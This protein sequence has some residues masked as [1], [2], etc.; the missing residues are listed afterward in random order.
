MSNSEKLGLYLMPY[1][2]GSFNDAKHLK[3]CIFNHLP[4]LNSFEFDIHLKMFLGDQA[5]YY[6][7]VSNHFPGGLYQHV[8][9]VFLYDER[10]FE[11]EFFLRISQ[12]FPLM[13]ELHLTNY[14]SNTNP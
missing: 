7:K 1:V 4:R 12:S 9:I 5:I 8:Y 6:Q 2:N 13:K 3:E 14:Q 10:P 11:H